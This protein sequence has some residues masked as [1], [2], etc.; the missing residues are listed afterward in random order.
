MGRA[1]ERDE[2]KTEEQRGGQRR[3][4]SRRKRKRRRRRWR[5]WKARL[6]Y[7]VYLFADTD[8]HEQ[9]Q[10]P[11][12][13][14]QSESVLIVE[15][16]DPTKLISRYSAKSPRY[17]SPTLQPSCLSSRS[18]ASTRA[19]APS[20]L[21]RPAPPRRSTP[22]F[23]ARDVPR[24]SSRPC[25]TSKTFCTRAREPVNAP[26]HGKIGNNNS[27]QGSTSRSENSK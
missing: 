5:R 13:P 26:D 7:G 11:D 23:R 25:R 2:E 18:S 15:L 17:C 19:P 24:H 4:R 10:H 14:G 9:N 21:R 22:P 16:I 8:K 12:I 6:M 27:A 1:G 3:R 20:P